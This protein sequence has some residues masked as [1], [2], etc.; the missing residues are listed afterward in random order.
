M[1]NR[2][3]RPVFFIDI[4]VPR[5]IDPKINRLPNAYVYDID[6]LNGIVKE[7]ISERNK[8][9]LKGERIVDE[10][11]IQFRQWYDNLSVVPT[12]VDLRGKIEAIATAEVEKAMKSLTDVNDKDRKTINKMVN[13]LV[14]KILHDPT[15]LLKNAGNQNDKPVLV[16]LTRKLFNLD[17]N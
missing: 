15:L 8:E 3:N 11:V 16:D 7:N 9:A 12:I 1:N 10:A 4:A 6:D 13:A 2:H 5:D 17:D 14:N